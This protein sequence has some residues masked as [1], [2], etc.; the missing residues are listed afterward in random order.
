MILSAYRNNT[1]VTDVSFGQVS[2]STSE[3]GHTVQLLAV[4]KQVLS[5]SR[6]KSK[7]FQILKL[8]GRALV[9]TQMVFCQMPPQPLLQPIKMSLSGKMAH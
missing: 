5:L 2:E 1:E 7:G 8:K 3:A 4:I 6:R 9:L